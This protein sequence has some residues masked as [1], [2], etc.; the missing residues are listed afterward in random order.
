MSIDELK[1]KTILIVEDEFFIS[2]DLEQILADAGAETVLVDAAGAA[3][4][5]L[6]ST[7]F[8]AVI[9]DIHLQDESTYPVADELRRREIPF[10]FLSGYLTIR[11]GYA[12]VPFLDKPFTAETVTNALNGI[13][14]QTT[15]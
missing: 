1:G 15:R 9:L 2:S 14:A 8:D 13:L 12:D 11:E 5:K 6:A 4:E 10:V 7:R 3:M